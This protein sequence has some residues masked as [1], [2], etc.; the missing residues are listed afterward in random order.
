MERRDII[1]LKMW[2]WYLLVSLLRVLSLV[3]RGKDWYTI[4]VVLE[5]VMLVILVA[6]L[7]EV[8][9]MNGVVCEI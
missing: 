3:A 1:S 7:V 6:N 5:F 2:L 8:F 9:A 4:V